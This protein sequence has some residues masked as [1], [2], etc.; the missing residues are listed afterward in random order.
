MLFAL[1]VFKWLTIRHEGRRY[2]RF[3]KYF[4]Q[5]YRLSQRKESKKRTGSDPDENDVSLYKAD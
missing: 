2:V 1:P 3:K 4:Q 5:A